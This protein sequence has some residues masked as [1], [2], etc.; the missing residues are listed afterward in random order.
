MSLHL[1]AFGTLETK[2]LA[3]LAE[4]R[5]GTKPALEHTRSITDLGVDQSSDGTGVVHGDDVGV[6]AAWERLGQA[7]RFLSAAVG[8]VDSLAEEVELCRY[9]VNSVRKVES[10]SKSGREN[11]IV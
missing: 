2:R 8:C 5:L 4:Q 11:T 3:V 1:C 10:W 9:I 6:E 7:E